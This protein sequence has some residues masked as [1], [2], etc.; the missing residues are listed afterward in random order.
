MGPF[1]AYSTTIASGA[2]ASAALD[3]Q[4]GWGA[5]YLV[6]P[7]MTSN[8]Q[9]HIQSSDVATGTYRRV[10]HPSINSSTVTTND[11]AIA[12][13]ATNCVVPIPAGLR[14]VKIETTATVDSGQAFKVLCG[15]L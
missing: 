1:S 13:S 5:T 2:T 11:F 10:K 8:T 12:S 9:I 14:F 6:V 4:F 3:L 7:S 15:S